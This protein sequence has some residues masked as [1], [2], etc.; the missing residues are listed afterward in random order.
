LGRHAGLPL[1]KPHII[2]GRRPFN[3]KNK[4]Q[5]TD[6]PAVFQVF[7]LQERAKHFEDKMLRPYYKQKAAHKAA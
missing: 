4:N 6:A 2:D 5:F 7:M 1:Q 3:S